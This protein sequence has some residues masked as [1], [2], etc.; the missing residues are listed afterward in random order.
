MTASAVA[1]GTLLVPDAGVSGVG[2]V[3][4]APPFSDATVT[5]SLAPQ[6]GEA[7]D[8]RTVR[9]ERTVRVDADGRNAVWFPLGRAVL[10]LGSRYAVTAEGQPS[11]VR[12]G[13]PEAEARR[14]PTGLGPEASAAEAS[15]AVVATETWSLRSALIDLR[16][17]VFR[18][19]G[20]IRFWATTSALAVLGWV[21]LVALAARRASDGPSSS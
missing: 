6:A 13:A 1:I 18:D 19:D 16:R 10:E 21:Y 15:L 17:V 20:V 2:L 3:I 9:L 4:K 12:F 14:R 7:I 11:S 8:A 5:I